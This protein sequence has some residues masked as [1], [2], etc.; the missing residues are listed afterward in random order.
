MVERIDPVHPFRAAVE[1]HDID[2]ALALMSDEVRFNSP[3]VFRPYN[4]IEAVGMILRAVER[5]FED[6]HYTGELTSPDGQHVALVFAA[7]IGDKQLE[8]CDFLRCRADG[9]IEELTVMVRPMSGA[10]ALAAAMQQQL[11]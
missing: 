7:H 3:V 1:A 9:V 6:F 5:V 11:T 10:I 2:A 4:G 8:G